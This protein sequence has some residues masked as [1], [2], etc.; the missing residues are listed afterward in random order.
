M[1]S[2]S[3]SGNTHPSLHERLNRIRRTELFHGD[4]ESGAAL[5]RR[6]EI[7]H[8]DIPEL[9]Q[10]VG[11]SLLDCDPIRFDSLQ[12]MPDGDGNPTDWHNGYLLATPTDD[13]IA[14]V[15]AVRAL[16]EFKAIVAIPLF[17]E[18][19]FESWRFPRLSVDEEADHFFAPLGEIAIEP[20]VS[21]FNLSE[22]DEDD[23]R[24][25]VA[26]ALGF[27]GNMHA[28][29]QPKISYHLITWLGRHNLQNIDSNSEIAC[30]LLDFK[31]IAAREAIRAA[32]DAGCIDPRVCGNWNEIEAE[33][34]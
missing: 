23:G 1:V 24:R 26:A 25:N 15:V 10:I 2:P 3:P 28:S 20:L 16:M 21:A 4:F 14:T 34:S 22:G 5:M 11:E 19:L 18:I 13:W 33:L 27:I 31:D 7:T 8:A 29:L 30:V 9:M 17:I 12:T 6:C 32:F